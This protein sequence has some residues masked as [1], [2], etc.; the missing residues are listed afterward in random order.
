MNLILS[1]HLLWQD[2][3]KLLSYRESKIFWSWRTE[4]SNFVRVNTAKLI[5]FLTKSLSHTV[6]NS[7]FSLFHAHKI[8]HFEYK[9]R[10]YLCTFP[11]VTFRP[12][13]K[14]QK[15]F[16]SS[17]ICW[18]GVNST[19]YRLSPSCQGFL[20][21]V[22]LN[23]IIQCGSEKWSR[24]FRPSRDGRNLWR[25]EN[26]SLHKRPKNPFL[27]GFNYNFTSLRLKI[28]FNLT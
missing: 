12:S 7:V 16:C 15:K 26:L 11:S 23:Y 22:L 8:W 21:K 20:A 6:P 9:M 28:S 3:E 17:I 1:L 24:I 18:F 2:V 14:F 25:T 19:K 4:S 13:R 27:P 5:P 10:Y